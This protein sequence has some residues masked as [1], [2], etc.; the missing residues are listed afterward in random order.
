MVI[1]GGVAFP[2]QE[3]LGPARHQWEGLDVSGEVDLALADCVDGRV[4]GGFG[5][6]GSR[7]STTTTQVARDTL[8]ARVRVGSAMYVL[9]YRRRVGTPAREVSGRVGS[10]S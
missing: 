4:G 7:V 8:A 3:D 9:F 1:F 5:E 10:L 2:C 6:G